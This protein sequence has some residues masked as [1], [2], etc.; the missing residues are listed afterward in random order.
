MI[1]KVLK[2]T[3]S[4]RGIVTTGLRSP[5]WLL[6]LFVSGMVLAQ[7]AEDSAEVLLRY[8]ETF[9][10]EL[11]EQQDAQWRQEEAPGD[12]TRGWRSEPEVP[13]G[14]GN[15]VRLGFDPTRQH[16]LNMREIETNEPDTPIRRPEP[17]SVMELQF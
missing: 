9:E 8:Q 6:W 1:A 15:R 13:A 12:A 7:Q 2:P 4:Y 3:P 11:F 14:P 17:A 5:V 10:K 16:E